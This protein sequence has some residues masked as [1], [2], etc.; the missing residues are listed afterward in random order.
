ML[1]LL[2]VTAYCRLGL[3]PTFTSL[4]HMTA[5]SVLAPSLGCA[6]IGESF[7]D[8]S[9]PFTRLAR[10]LNAV[11]LPDAGLARRLTVRPRRHG[12]EDLKALVRQQQLL[13]TLVE[14]DKF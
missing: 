14:L 8:F 1:L 7:E 5:R 3:Q 13:H 9:L 10:A 12:L 6:R 11:C 2:R 4:A